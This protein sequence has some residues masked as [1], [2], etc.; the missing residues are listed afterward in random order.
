MKQAGSHFERTKESP[1]LTR[2]QQAG[3]A[4]IDTHDYGVSN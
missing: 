3:S 2:L 4:A 1:F